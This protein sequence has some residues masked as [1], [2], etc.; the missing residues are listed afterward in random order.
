MN[1]YQRTKFLNAMIKYSPDE[2]AKHLLRAPDGTVYCDR[3]KLVKDREEES[4]FFYVLNR[5]YLSG[6]DDIEILTVFFDIIDGAIL[7]GAY[8]PES[9]RRVSGR[10]LISESIKTPYT[11]SK[12]DIEKFKNILNNA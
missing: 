1:E 5:D 10:P 6:Y 11:Y 2:L 3:S 9:G 12:A 7:G 8:N 4:Q